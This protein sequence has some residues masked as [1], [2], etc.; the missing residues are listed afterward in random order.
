MACDVSPVAMFLLKYVHL[1]SYIFNIFVVCVL[2][3]L[4]CLVL[5]LFYLI[6]IPGAHVAK[7]LILKGGRLG[8]GTTKN[9]L[10]TNPTKTS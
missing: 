10:A 6:S 7:N 1:T 2:R 3:I 9:L 5:V 8:D 4:V